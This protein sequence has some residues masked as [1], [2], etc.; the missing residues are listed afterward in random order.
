MAALV[1]VVLKVQCTSVGVAVAAGVVE[2][3]AVDMGVVKVEVVAV[4]EDVG[5]GHEEIACT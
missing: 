5:V 2:D 4:I 3:V 1:G